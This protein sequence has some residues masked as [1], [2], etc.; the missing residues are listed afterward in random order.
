M[1]PAFAHGVRAT[2]PQQFN[3]GDHVVADISQ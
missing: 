2:L 1:P 3:V